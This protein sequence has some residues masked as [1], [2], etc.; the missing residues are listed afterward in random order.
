MKSVDIENG[1]VICDRE[2]A[3]NNLIADYER[4]LAEARYELATRT[5]GFIGLGCLMV[6]FFAGR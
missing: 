2:Q 4:R 5:L 6:A 1:A 3:I